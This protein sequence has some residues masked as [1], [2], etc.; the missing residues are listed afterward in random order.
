M[1]SY[2]EVYFTIS[3]QSK[4]K[5]SF[6]QLKLLDTETDWAC[7]VKQQ[8]SELSIPMSVQ[9]EGE[10]Q[11]NV[12]DAIGRIPELGGRLSYRYWKL[13]TN[14]MLVS[15]AE[16]GSNGFFP[17][18][19]LASLWCNSNTVAKLRLRRQKADRLGVSQW[20]CGALV[21]VW[22]LFFSCLFF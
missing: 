12:R 20:T 5:R 19:T 7:P 11:W 9:A 13:L 4:K 18:Q 14:Q 8:R 10:G 21:K 6:L 15:W 1:R 17:S 16:E 2:N 3:V 22:L